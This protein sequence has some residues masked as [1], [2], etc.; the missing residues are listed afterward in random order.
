MSD[1]LDHA[2]DDDARAD[3]DRQLVLER[4]LEHLLDPS[5]D[6]RLAEKILLYFAITH[7]EASE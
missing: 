6:C 3:G 2:T 4:L 7:R 1:A 5:L